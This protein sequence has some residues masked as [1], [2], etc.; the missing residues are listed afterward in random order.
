MS[1]VDVTTK[2]RMAHKVKNAPFSLLGSLPLVSHPMKKCPHPLLW[3]FALDKYNVSKWR[4]MIILD[5]LIMV[6]SKFVAK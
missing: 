1:A 3:V 5:A 2:L 6:A 4:F